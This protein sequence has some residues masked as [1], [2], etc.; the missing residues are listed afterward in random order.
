MSGLEPGEDISISLTNDLQIMLETID[1]Q[2]FDASRPAVL[3]YLVRAG[4]A[5]ISRGSTSLPDTLEFDEKFI[6]TGMVDLT[7]NGATQLLPTYT[8]DVWVTGS[9]ASGNPFNSEN[10]NLYSPLA[11]WGLALTGPD[12]SLRSSETFW[13]WSNPTPNPDESVS[14]TIETKNMGSTGNVTFVLQQLVDDQNWKTVDTNEINIPSGSD[15]QLKLETVADFSIGETIEYR[16]LLIDSGVEKERISIA[17][18]LIKEEVDRDGAALANQVA[19]SQLSV[20]MYLIALCAMSYAVWTM[21][22]IRKI[23]KGDEFDEAD[24]TGEVIENM[25]GKEIPEIEQL[26]SYAPQAIDATPAQPVPSGPPLPPTGLPE[27]WTMEQW[28][29]YGHQYLEMQ[30]RK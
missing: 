29:A 30:S 27:G 17:P 9:D 4:E 28:T 16:L 22:Q 12:V 15:A 1:D 5:E 21:V 7:D 8:I 18:L 25:S 11:S 23:R 26:D 13:T 20:I 3:H 6:W 10:N 14:L 24:Q 2:G 19:D